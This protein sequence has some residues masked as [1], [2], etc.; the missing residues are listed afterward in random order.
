MQ[1]LA[2]RTRYENLMNSRLPEGTVFSSKPRSGVALLGGGKA[3]YSGGKND[4]E[5]VTEKLK[6]GQTAL[7]VLHAEVKPN[8]D[9]FLGVN[10][11]LVGKASVVHTGILVTGIRQDVMVAV[12]AIKE[13]DLS[14]LEWVVSLA[15]AGGMS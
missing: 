8:F 14:E 10:P 9:C 7:I 3:I 15:M 5:P 1:S 2:N 4:G 6:S 12:T 13:T 11:A